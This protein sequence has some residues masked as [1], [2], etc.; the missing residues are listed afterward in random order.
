[1]KK[2]YVFLAVLSLTISA[3]ANPVSKKTA[4]NI[5]KSFFAKQLPEGGLSSNGKSDDTPV[6]MAY[7]SDELYV[8]NGQSGFVVVSADDQTTPVLG[9]SDAKQFDSQNVNPATKEWLEGYKEQI[10]ALKD[11]KILKTTTLSNYAPVKPLVPFKW[12]QSEPYNKL[13]HMDPKTDERCIAGCP[14]TA[15]AQ[16]LATVKYPE[17]IMPRGIP[18][19]YL[20]KAIGNDRE[21][22]QELDALPATSFNWSKMAEKYNEDDESDAPDEVAKL[23]KYAGYA[24]GMEYG[25]SFSGAWINAACEAARLYFG[26]SEVG[27]L[28][29]NTCTYQYFED[30][31]YNELKAGRPVLY[32]ASAISSTTSKMEGHAFIIDGYKDGYYH[33]NWG[34]GG[35]SDG[36]FI[37]SVLNSDYQ[38]E[39]GRKVGHGYD[40]FTSIVYGF[41]KPAVADPLDGVNAL[42]VWLVEISDTKTPNMSEIVLNRA[43]ETE[44]FP[45]FIEGVTFDRDISP[46]IDKEY[47]IAWNLYNTESNAYVFAEPK[48]RLKQTKILSGERKK[49]EFDIT[50]P[51]DVDDGTYQILWFFRD[52]KAEKNANKWYLCP[53]ADAFSVGMIIKGNK[54]TVWPTCDEFERDDDANINSVTV[55]GDAKVYNTVTLKFNASNYSNSNNKDVYLWVSADGESYTMSDGAGTGIDKGKSGDFYLT[56]FPDVAGKWD[57]ALMF[58]NAEEYF[59]IRNNLLSEKQDE[60][61][62][63]GSSLA[64]TVSNIDEDPDE[65]DGDSEELLSDKIEGEYTMYTG[66]ELPCT[67]TMYIILKQYDKVTD[68]YLYSSDPSDSHN[69][70]VERTFVE[71]KPLYG[72]FS[73]SNLKKDVE[74]KLAVGELV[75]GKVESVYDYSTT[76]IYKS[77]DPSIVNE[78]GTR[79]AKPA[80]VKYI[81][82]GKV[83]IDDKYNPAGQPVTW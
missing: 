9:W 41:K 27:Q 33:V 72:D 55:D 46:Y 62:V 56:F 73:F 15:L 75:D 78:V 16:I 76:Y 49:F 42:P 19:Q 63:G 28:Y 1:M 52:C 66:D 39:K 71:D 67:R 47:D 77:D 31:L 32:S 53:L 18:A 61:I 14:A 20:Y 80:P 4:A 48:V 69:I 23:I 10:Q 57:I 12:D 35:N 51:K 29:R 37:L 54:L 17:G 83:I 70:K 43:D 5:A 59:D 64:Y 30:F 82:D 22:I 68:K 74:Y 50:I 21:L 3:M 40:L 13:L 45:A 25:S 26:Y 81:K 44:D 79:I 36:Y 2:I 38:E 7:E 60:V 65:E 6:V 11:D 34:W 58:T 8:F 24:Q